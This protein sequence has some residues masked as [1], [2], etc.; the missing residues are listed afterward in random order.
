MSVPRYCYAKIHSCMILHADCMCLKLYICM[1]AIVF[2]FYA[3]NCICKYWCIPEK[4]SHTIID[5]YAQLY[6]PVAPKWENATKCYVVQPQ[7]PVCMKTYGQSYF[8]RGAHNNIQSNLNLYFQMVR[9][10]NIFVICCLCL[11][12]YSPLFCTAPCRVICGSCIM[13]FIQSSVLSVHISSRDSSN[14]SFQN[15]VDVAGSDSAY[16]SAG[17]N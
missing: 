17:L 1:H 7:V 9:L 5:F 11:S 6:S 4:E 2:F 15:C 13:V 8:F 10:Y 14:L 16:L 3:Y 12:F